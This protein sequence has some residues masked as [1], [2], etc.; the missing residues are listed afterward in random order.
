V[1]RANEAYEQIAKWHNELAQI[2]LKRT[3]RM[4]LAK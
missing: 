1:Q 4:T 2:A 3:A